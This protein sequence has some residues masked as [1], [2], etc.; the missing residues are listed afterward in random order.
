MGVDRSC[1]GA[2]PFYLFANNKR[3]VNDFILWLACANSNIKCQIEE[4]NK[5]RDQIYRHWNAEIFCA[6]THTNMKSKYIQKCTVYEIL[7]HRFSEHILLQLKKKRKKK[8]SESETITS[9]LL[10]FFYNACN[11]LSMCNSKWQQWH[12]W[13]ANE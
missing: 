5:N 4:R 7:L 3:R 13:F 8:T 10:S 2:V 1:S 9:F 6:M 12:D 11:N